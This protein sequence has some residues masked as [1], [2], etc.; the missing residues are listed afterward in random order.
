M[1]PKQ[2][3][4]VPG[5]RSNPMPGPN[6]RPGQNGPVGKGGPLAKPGVAAAAAAAVK[7]EPLLPIEPTVFQKYSTQHEFPLSSMASVVAHCLVVL[8]A[9][10]AGGLIFQWGS[11][12]EPPDVDNIVFAGGGGDGEGGGTPDGEAD[13]K[14]VLQFD[15]DREMNDTPTVTFS[16]DDI[17]ASVAETNKERI[18]E[19]ARTAEKQA[20]GTNPGKRA[21]DI[22]LGGPGSGG[23]RGAGRGT[24]IGDGEGPGVM[25]QRAYRKDR[26]EILIRFTS[27]EEYVEK[28]GKLDSMIAFPEGNGQFRLFRDLKGKS[29]TVETSTGLS[30]LNRIW[31]LNNDPEAVGALAQALGMTTS[32]GRAYIF[33]PISLEQA[34]L[35]KELDTS[36][37]TEAQLN[38]RKMLTT[39]TVEKAGNGW[40]VKVIEQGKRKKGR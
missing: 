31:W 6:Q 7:E 15:P 12:H 14:E 10:I 18:I 28:L 32:P 30:K 20:R 1:T 23:G 36:K 11:N 26:W 35:K 2:P 33:V 16:A 9:A 3:S 22:G 21:G 8:M 5:N 37:M 19:E 39:F 17:A 40:D 13:L 25:T 27:G 24:G 29:A 38:E 4:N 34:L